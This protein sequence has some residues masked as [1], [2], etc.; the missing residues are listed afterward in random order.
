[1]GFPGLYF[2][3]DDPTFIPDLALPSCPRRHYHISLPGH[4]AFPLS[5]GENFVHTHFDYEDSL[6]G[7]C[8]R[9]EGKVK[10]FQ[11]QVNEGKFFEPVSVKKLFCVFS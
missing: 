1:M 6:G 10:L 8:Q 11:Q 4:P 5:P 7:G 3:I 2:I 9:Q